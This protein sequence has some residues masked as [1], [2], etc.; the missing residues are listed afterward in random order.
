MVRRVSICFLVILLPFAMFA[1]TVGKIAGTVVDKATGEPLTG[2]NII[3]DDESL[4][5]GAA[6]DAEGYY[7]ILN[8][9]VGGY[10]V[11]A[12][13]IGYKDVVVQ[14]VRV[15]LDLTTEM[16]FELEVTA[17]E[18]EEVMVTAQRPMI[19]KDETNTNI[20]KSAEEI[21]HLP[22]RSIQDIVGTVA[23]VVKEENSGAMNVRGGRSSETAVYIDGVFVNDPYN[24]AVRIHLPA[25]AIEEMSV[26]TGGFNAEYGE[27]MSGIIAITTNAGTDRYSASVEAVTDEFLSADKEALGAYSYGFNEYTMTLS[28]PIIPKKKHTF[29]F[30][31]V[32]TY[33]ADITPS[34]GWA[35][36]PWRLDD[37]TYTHNSYDPSLFDEY[38][39]AYDTTFAAD[40]TTVEDVTSDTTSIK[41]YKFNARL[42]K[43]ASSDWS[44][45]GKIKLQLGKKMELKS[46]ISQTNRQFSADFLG[47]AAAIQPIRFFDTEH[48]PLYFTDTQS[49]N[50]TL[51]HTLSGHTFYDLKFM[52]F[53]T[54]VKCYDPTFKDD[55][56]KYGDP[57]Y[58][59]WPDEAQYYGEAYTGRLGPDFFQPYSQYDSYYKQRTTYWGIDF[60]LTHQQGKYHTL[61]AG[62]EYKYHTLRSIRIYTPTKLADPDYSTEIEK[63][64]AADIRFYGYDVDGN[65]VDDGDYF[66]TEF[67]AN[68]SPTNDAWKKQAPYNPII[69]SGYLQ[70]KVEFRDLILNLGLRYDHIN[71]NGWMFKEIAAQYIDAD[72]KVNY[73]GNGTYVAGTGMFGGDEAFTR[74][75]V[76]DS[77]TYY[78]IS[79]R[80]GMSF[81]VTDMTVFHAQ[82]GIFYQAPRL[83]DLY[84]SPFYLDRYVKSG[85]Y[86]TSLDNPNLRPPK[87]ISYEI[88]F[89]QRLG[90]MAALQLTAFYKETEDLVQLINE[91]TDVTNIAFYQNGDY[92]TIKGLDVIFTLRRWK[93]LSATMNYEMQFAN[94]TGSASG[95]NF[96]IAWQG[97]ARGHFPKYAQPLAFEQ[98]HTG[99][100]NLDYR[101]GQEASVPAALK[102]FGANMQ[103]AFNSGNPFTRAKIVNNFPFNGRY[104]N[105]A[106][107]EQPLSAVNSEV[108]PWVF[109]IDL[110]ID[111]GFYIGKA[112]LT[113]YAW[114]INLL[115]TA[116]VKDV[117]I[118]TGLPNDTGYLGTAPGKTYWNSLD[119]TGK[120][121]YKMREWDYNNYGVPRQIRLGLMLEI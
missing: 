4:F 31:G 25:S 23:G 69:M 66:D 77:E 70:D 99:T 6:S 72:G 60:D 113:A 46:S 27:A 49:I 102:N 59:P 78:Y 61:K 19:R 64:R 32:R 14:G 105:D 111:K 15:S 42:P 47:T 120:A 98:R 83:T 81:P 37:Y 3:I 1:A 52:H 63:Y 53:D 11:R 44:Y 62:F 73:N 67:D 48:R 12:S 96:D 8:V 54:E 51:T 39:V 118:T 57:T 7:S 92:G 20:I 116:N 115:N 68:L 103:F 56:E 76:V 38:Q 58:N 86:F 40:G 82:Y 91:T 109:R 93:N 21:Q 88:G 65:E 71:P 10:T 22:I 34:Y 75:D 89:K 104:D 36:N 13:Y 95:G 24:Y 100:L 17:L 119:D 94:G 112:K 117:Y 80:L 84:S 2:V 110:K 87:T 50:T 79:P 41:N 106:L 43:N 108:S 121:L 74:E 35:Y 85:G 55:L 101:L 45:T 5:L 33:R 9:P 18:F 26:Q 90:E 114:V 28:G 97:G 29:F 30:S 107:S 16:N